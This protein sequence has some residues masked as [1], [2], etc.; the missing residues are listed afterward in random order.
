MY[1]PSLCPIIIVCRYPRYSASVEA[2]RYCYWCIHVYLSARDVVCFLQDTLSRQFFQKYCWQKI[3][4]V[5]GFCALCP[6]WLNLLTY[7]E[8]DN[9]LC[10]KFITR[11]V[12][13]VGGRGYISQSPAIIQALL[14]LMYGEEGADTHTRRNCL[15]A[16]QK[17]SLR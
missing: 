8:A 15:G 17:L 14:Y 6:G 3:H 13:F 5:H 10:I 1:M 2:S 12:F 11:C 4:N 16:I 7:V 9:S